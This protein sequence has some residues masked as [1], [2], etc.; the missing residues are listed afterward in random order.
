MQTSEVHR[1]ANN[2][3]ISSQTLHNEPLYTAVPVCNPITLRPVGSDIFILGS[4]SQADSMFSEESRGSQC[5]SNALCALIYAKYTSLNT[6]KDLDKVLLEGDLLYKRIICNLHRRNLF[7]SSLINFDELPHVVNVFN[8]DIRIQKFP[9]ISGVCTQQFVTMH[10]PY[11]Y[12]ALDTAFITH[13]HILVMTGIVCSAV[14][15]KENQYFFFDSHS[16]C[17]NGLSSENGTSLLILFHQLQDLVTFMYAVY[18]SM[19]IDLTNQFD[20]LPVT[21]TNDSSVDEHEQTRGVEDQINEN[22]LRSGQCEHTKDPVESVEWKTVSYKKNNKSNRPQNN[23]C[24]RNYTQNSTIEYQT[25]LIGKYFRDQKQKQKQKQ[26][27]NKKVYDHQEQKET[28]NQK[29]ADRNEYFRLY[30]QKERESA[31]FKKNEQLYSLASKRKARESD[32]FKK[33]EQLYSLASKR[34]ARESDDF[35]KNE[36]LYSLA[37]KRKARESDDFKKNEQLYSLA[38]K[39]KAR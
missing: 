38:S 34:K 23:A 1:R 20:L 36:Q 19:L 30:R 27:R 10:L 21:F 8:K 33:N 11:L 39:R 29:L 17:L 12:Q 5:T 4:F 35:K 9:V 31:D 13:S 16:H 28:K 3:L 14:F 24:E 32:D 26:I 22:A 25:L 2:S 37:S 15:H 6:R 18:E 7:K